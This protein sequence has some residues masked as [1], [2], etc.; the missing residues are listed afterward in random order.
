MRFASLDEREDSEDQ[1]ARS[2]TVRV[3]SSQLASA[4]AQVTGTSQDVAAQAL[5]LFDLARTLDLSQPQRVDDPPL[6]AMVAEPP[7]APTNGAEHW[8]HSVALVQ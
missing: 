1:R 7:A 4:M 8:Q 5:V 2:Q 6:G 3:S